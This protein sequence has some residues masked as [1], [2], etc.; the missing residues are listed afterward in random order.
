[1]KFDCR[2]GGMRRCFGPLGAALIVGLVAPLD[3]AAAEGADSLA[4]VA[5]LIDTVESGF[6]GRILMIELAQAPAAAGPAQYDVKLLTDEGNVLRL[7]YDART[8]ELEAVEGRGEGA[9]VSAEE[10]EE[11]EK[12]LEDEHEEGDDLEPDRDRGDGGDDNSG[13]GS[14]DD[15]HGGDS[16]GPGSGDDSGGG[17]GSAGSGSSG[18]GSSGSGGGGSDDGPDHN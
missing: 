9:R 14:G 17:S 16:S 1:M 12:E 5:S 4:P 15:R 10:E 8:L 18:S 7:H 3:A 13:P 6:G 11:L 2:S